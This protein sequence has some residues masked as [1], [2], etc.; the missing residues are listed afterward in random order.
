MTSPEPTLKAPLSGVT[1]RMYNPGFG[2]CLLLAFRA[3]DGSPRYLLIDCGAHHRYPN[4]AAILNKVAADIGSA[5]GNHLHVVAATHQHTDHLDGFKLAAD[6]FKTIQI[7]D[8]WLA[9]TEDPDDPIANDLRQAYGKQIRALFGMA[10]QLGA[11]HHPLAEALTRILEF[12]YPSG[13]GSV[14]APRAGMD[15][16]PPGPGG[17]PPEEDDTRPES[18][19]PF[20]R[21]QAR[22]KLVRSQDY[23]H[24]EEPPLSLPDVKGIKIYVLGPPRKQAMIRILERKNELYPEL[25]ALNETDA[26]AAAVLAANGTEKLT[27][28]EKDLFERSQPFGKAYIIPSD[29]AAEHPEYGKFFK[30][31]YG[32]SKREEKNQGPRWRRID[33]DW[34]GS[35][36]NLALSI[37]SYTNNT[38]LVLAVEICESGKVLLFAADAQT[39]N[40]LSW[41]DLHWPGEGPQGAEVNS[42]D[43][44]KRTVLYKVGHHGSRNATLSQKGL[45]MMLSPDLVAMIPVDEQ[46]AKNEMDWEHPAP[47]LLAKLEQKTL[48]R[49]IRSDQ[50]PSG[51]QAPAQPTTLRAAEWQ[52]FVEQLD[53]DR[54][55]DRLWIQFT[56]R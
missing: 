45:E 24:P 1:V 23:R 38:S 51:N 20:L 7:D 55:P 14:A 49:V 3:E 27:P 53:W 48:G 33:M 9:W 31:H 18:P 26:F 56:V 37:N 16:V 17:I 10:Q 29:Q 52:K 54:G 6:V 42:P 36:E 5:T 11:A 35:G 41:Q 32:F 28:A 25:T 43:L 8:L 12:E 44:L 50:I 34:I 2:D 47:T 30:A 22:N 13:L 15:S 46:W 40:W 39:G 21:K 19:L 4:R